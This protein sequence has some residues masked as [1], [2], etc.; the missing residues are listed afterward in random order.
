MPWAAREAADVLLFQLSRRGERR[1]LESVLR[2]R[3]CLNRSIVAR[4]RKGHIL[5][6]SGPENWSLRAFVGSGVL[7]PRYGRERGEGGTREGR[8]RPLF[9]VCSPCVGIAI[10]PG[11]HSLIIRGNL[12]RWRW[13]LNP[14]AP[15]SRTVDTPPESAPLL[16]ISGN[17]PNYRG[18][19]RGPEYTGNTISLG[20]Q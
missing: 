18:D 11:Y 12:W 8:L 7:F 20:T 17:L 13:D 9:A 19:P 2:L 3:A 4:A 5:S 16:D 15:V 6:W 1:R 10:P 14:M